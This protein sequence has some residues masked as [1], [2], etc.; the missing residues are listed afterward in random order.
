MSNVN[1]K[2]VIDNIRAK[3]TVYTPI[4]ETIVN[5]IQAIESDGETN[6]EIAIRVHREKQLTIDDSL[7]DV[8]SFKIEDN[9]I[10]FTDEHYQSFDTLYTDLKISEGG[11]GFGRF[12]CLKY[13]QDLHVESVYRDKDGFKKRKFSMGKDNDIIVNESVAESSEHKSGAVVHLSVLKERISIDKK[14]KTIARNLVEKLLPFFIAQDYSCPK[15]VLS[16]EDGS[17][18]ILL[19][20]SCS[21]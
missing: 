10:G 17:E 15:T 6:G 20:D 21:N 9:G 13:F 8:R 19:N 11:K 16:E 5:S 2:R 1:I 12:I 18:S 14:L 7:T 3:T 4:V